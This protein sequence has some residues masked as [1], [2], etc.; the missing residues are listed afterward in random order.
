V[1]GCILEAE[2]Y[3]DRCGEHLRE[4]KRIADLLRAH[5]PAARKAAMAYTHTRLDQ[6]ELEEVAML[7]L[8][9]AARRFKLN[10][11]VPFARFAALVIGLRLHDAGA[12]AARQKNVIVDTSIRWLENEDGG[13]LEVFEI[14]PDTTCGPE[15]IAEAREELSHVVH[16]M[17]F[18]LTD[19]ERLALQGVLN[20]R[21]YD[22]IVVQIG[23]NRR[24]VDNAVQRARRKLRAELQ[25]A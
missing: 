18:V 19:T 4:R 6:Q 14:L 16:A 15:R 1:P 13:E 9:E 22:D 20:D 12:K 11:G 17:N 3:R 5:A 23:G 7:A 21:S 2:P 24:T 8:W 25:A 10:H